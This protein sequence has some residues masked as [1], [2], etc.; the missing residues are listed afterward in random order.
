MK[1]AAIGLLLLCAVLAAGERP[2]VARASVMAMEKSFDARLERMTSDPYLL[3]GMSRGVYLDGFGVV[4]TAEVNLAIAPGAGPFRPAF[5]KEDIARLRQQ[6]LERLPILRETM[7]KML[8][9]AAASLDGV[10]VTELVVVGVNIFRYSFEDPAGIPDQIVMQA[11][12]QNLLELQSGRG[13]RAALESS[14][15]VKEY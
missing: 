14:I 7:R 10:P 15:Q 13:D 4:F 1:R 3:L 11:P 8:L 2:K 12:R 9:D 5:T 6:K